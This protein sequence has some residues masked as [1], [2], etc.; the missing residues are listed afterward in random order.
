MVYK[1][2]DRKFQ[3]I[4]SFYTGIGKSSVLFPVSFLV[5]L[6]QGVVTLGAIF[7][8]REV[9]SATPSQVGYFTA[10]WS[11]CYILGCIFL[12][13]LTNRILPR[14]ALIGATFLKSIFIV[15]IVLTDDIT[16]AYIFYGF[17][18][19]SIA[20]FWP[21]LMGWLSH[22][23]EGAQLGKLISKFNLSW[24]IGS[25][26][27]PLLAGFLSQKNPVYPLFMGCS[28]F[29]FGGLLLTG[30]SITLPKIRMDKVMNSIKQSSLSGTDNSTPLRFPAWFGI[31]TTYTVIGVIVN[32]FPLFALDRINFD[33]STVGFLLQGRAIFT[34]FGFLII[35]RTTFWH[36]RPAPMLVSQFALAVCVLFL[37][38]ISSLTSHAVVL[39]LM[40]IFMAF[41]YFNSLFHSVS[42]STNRAGRMAVHESL[43]SSGLIVGSAVGGILYQKYTM[44]TVYS[45]CTGIILF[46]LLLQGSFSWWFTRKKFQNINPDMV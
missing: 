34:T 38:Y 31:F 8:I 13:P 14:Y 10:L 6:G 5:A 1:Y 43:I 15:M 44:S 36:F 22:G 41:N 37:N 20:F 33:K 35:G 40:G 3:V 16:Y 23:I 26:I 30:A 2:I 39:G 9:F 7:Y 18:G 46:G 45:F 42:G 17:F 4:K 28:F 21:P 29:L 12:R 25:I 27:S 32:I 24:S 19:L 11:L